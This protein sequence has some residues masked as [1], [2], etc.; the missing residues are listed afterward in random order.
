MTAAVQETITFSG[1][2]VRLASIESKFKSAFLSLAAAPLSNLML[3]RGITN[4][5]P[6]AASEKFSTRFASLL[7]VSLDEHSAP[8][9]PPGCVE[10]DQPSIAAAVTPSYSGSKLVSGGG[11]EQL[12][13]FAAGKSWDFC[14]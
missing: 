13:A 14:I 5:F 11:P 1:L 10:C 6:L 3:S 2:S 9:S 4:Y 12:S 8:A 7:V